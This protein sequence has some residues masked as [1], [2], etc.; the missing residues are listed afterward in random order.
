MP[1]NLGLL[2]SNEGLE[3]AAVIEAVRTGRLSASIQI[4]IADRHS[5]ALTLARTAGFYGVFVPRSPYHANRDGF[6]RRLVEVLTQAEVQL[7]VLAGYEREPGPVL[8]EAFPGRLFGQGL[9][10][11]ELVGRLAGETSP[12]TLVDGPA[13]SRDPGGRP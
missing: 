7:V 8:A 11:E 12:L 2:C 4:V 5:A 9:G 13:P 10:P 1:L 6:E 3:L